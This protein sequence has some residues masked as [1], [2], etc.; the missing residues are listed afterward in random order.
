M[1]HFGNLT[2]SA[3]EDPDHD[4]SSNL[5]EFLGGTDPND[6]T[7]NFTLGSLALNGQDFEMTWK[8][9]AGKTYQLQ[10]CP[11]L[12]SGAWQDVDGTTVAISSLTH[13]V[14]SIN[15]QTNR[16]YRLKLVE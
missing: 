15:G 8:T 3:A 5:N 4:G 12:G 14:T 1:V 7:S 11:A 9:V 16:F 2:S 10:F 6:I 13:I